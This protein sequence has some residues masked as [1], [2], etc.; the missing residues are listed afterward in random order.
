[1]LF[2]QCL[3]HVFD[4]LKKLLSFQTTV[5][6]FLKNVFHRTGDFF[7]AENSQFTLNFIFL[8]L[9]F[10]SKQFHKEKKNSPLKKFTT[11]DRCFVSLEVHN[12]DWR[13]V[14]HI[15]K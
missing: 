14:L 9:Y 11:L 8:N 1:V 15:P 12:M 13:A 3:V 5:V 6:F 2:Q 7:F 10:F 4:F